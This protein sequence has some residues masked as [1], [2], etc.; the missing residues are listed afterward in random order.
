M[1][2]D[3]NLVLAENLRRLMD[4]SGDSQVKVAKRG[5]LSQRNVG[6]VATYG[7]THT[8]SPTVRTVDGLAKAFGVAPWMLF[9]P[10]LPLEL[11]QSTRMATLIQNYVV[12]SDAGRSNI[13]RTADAEVRYAAV[14]EQQKLK[15]G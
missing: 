7:T 3:S 8:T 1:S 2:S 9:V 6:N 15:A 12:C 10:N 4:A 11:F 14:S 5:G 13:E